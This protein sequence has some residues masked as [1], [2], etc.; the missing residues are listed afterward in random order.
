MN[1]KTMVVRDLERDRDLGRDREWWN[2]EPVLVDNQKIMA[3]TYWT[4]E[5]IQGLR[6]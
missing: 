3:S 1:L 6:V 4:A 2:L 5:D